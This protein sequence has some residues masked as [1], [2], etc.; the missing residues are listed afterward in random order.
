[1]RVVVVGQGYV[2]LR[3]ADPHTVESGSDGP[4]VEQSFS[5]MVGVGAC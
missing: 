1:M 5:E 2:G 3:G 4:Q